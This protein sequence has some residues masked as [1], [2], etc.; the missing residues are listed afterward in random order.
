MYTISDV[1]RARTIPT[2]VARAK[3]YDY[4]LQK[5]R[6]HIFV[7]VYLIY[8]LSK[9]RIS[10]NAVSF[11]SG[12][13]GTLGAILLTFPHWTFHLAAVVL[14]Q[15]WHFLDYVDGGLARLKNRESLAGYFWDSYASLIIWNA[16][17]I[18]FGLYVSH[19][20]GSGFFYYLVPWIP[21]FALL[22]LKLQYMHK[23]INTLK[24]GDKNKKELGMTAQVISKAS[25]GQQTVSLTQRVTDRNLA[26]RFLIFWSRANNVT[27]D[28]ICLLVLVE[29]FSPV[30]ISWIYFVFLFAT[31]FLEWV[32]RFRL[33]AWGN[34]LESTI[35]ELHQATTN[36]EKLKSST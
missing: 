9:T 3:W 25:Q 12:C 7:S 20:S 17:L 6:F 21:L 5:S 15:I 16:M 35:L 36:L 29:T 11:A 23:L 13:I 27:N 33:Y 4:N 34:G 26:T 19:K 10:P 2:H 24:R 28:L 32:Y 31:K 14:F 30:F 1:K 8:L 22:D 18:G